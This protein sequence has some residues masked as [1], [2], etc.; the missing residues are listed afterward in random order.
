M[1]SDDDKHILIFAQNSRDRLLLINVDVENQRSK[2]IRHLELDD[3]MISYDLF[4]WLD[5]TQVLVRQFKSG[6]AN[7]FRLNSDTGVWHEVKSPIPWES[8]T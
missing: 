4:T 8:M 2:V 1:W 5:D 7:C 3:R 6:F